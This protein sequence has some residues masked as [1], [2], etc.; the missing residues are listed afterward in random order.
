M[1]K[2]TL[3]YTQAK[4]AQRAEKRGL[5]HNGKPDVERH[6]AEMRAAL[7]GKRARRAERRRA[8]RNRARS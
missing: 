5:M 8:E 4:L 7:P 1:G 2:T 3:G 6:V